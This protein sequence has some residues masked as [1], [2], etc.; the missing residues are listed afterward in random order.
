MLCMAKTILEDAD[1]QRI[2]AFYWKGTDHDQW[3]SYNTWK[4]KWHAIAKREYGVPCRER[5]HRTGD[6]DRA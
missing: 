3:V 6:D 4:E 2:V 1:K 5:N